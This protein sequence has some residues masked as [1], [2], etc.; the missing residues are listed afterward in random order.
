MNKVYLVQTHEVYE[1]IST[2]RNEIFAT[3]EMAQKRFDEEVKWY[4]DDIGDYGEIIDDTS[5]YFSWVR[6][7]GYVDNYIEVCIQE[8]EVQGEQ[9]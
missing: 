9:L 6:E 7:S 3:K 1:D 2:I 8:Y 4:K 5:D